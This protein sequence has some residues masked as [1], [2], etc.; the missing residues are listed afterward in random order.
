MTLTAGIMVNLHP[1]THL[2]INVP[3]AVGETLQT[4]LDHTIMYSLFLLHTKIYYGGADGGSL[5]R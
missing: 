2:E 3:I 4:E 5:L 1:T